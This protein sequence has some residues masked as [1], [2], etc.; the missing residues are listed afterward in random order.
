M[1]PYTNQKQAH[2]HRKQ[3]YSYH[4]GEGGKGV[5]I[6]NMELTDKTTIQ[7]ADKQ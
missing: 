2:S 5:Q 3:T 4:R 1:N 7:K 6:R